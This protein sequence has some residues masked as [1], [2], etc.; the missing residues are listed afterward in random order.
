MIDI[1]ACLVKKLMALPLFHLRS[2]IFG[3][4]LCVHKEEIGHLKVCFSVVQ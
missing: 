2:I 3:E 4:I 1:Y